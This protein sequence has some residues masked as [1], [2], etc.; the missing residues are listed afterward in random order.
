MGKQCFTCSNKLVREL[1]N[2]E[3]KQMRKD[4]VSLFDIPDNEYKCKV[5]GKLI[6]QIDPACEHYE[7]HQLLEKI[8]GDLSAWAKKSNF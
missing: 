6:K 3:R 7:G 5:S 1:T 2:D 8:R 4:G